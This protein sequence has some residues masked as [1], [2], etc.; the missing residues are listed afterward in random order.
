MSDEYPEGVEFADKMGDRLYLSV[1]LGSYRWLRFEGLS[2]TSIYVFDL[3]T[4][5]RLRDELVRMVQLLEN[6]HA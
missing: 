2:G 5:R 4:A 6:P 3:D 1:A